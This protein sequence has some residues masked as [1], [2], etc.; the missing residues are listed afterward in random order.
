[1][2]PTEELKEEHDAIKRMLRILERMA[3]RLDAREDV[4]IEDIREAI[5]F[6]QG[7][8]DRCHH[9]KEED[10]LFPAM[11]AAGVPRQTGPIA[12]MLAEHEQGRAH[13]RA[14]IKALDEHVAGVS[15]AAQRLADNAR[16]YTALLR[17]HIDKEDGILYVIA[18]ARLSPRQQEELEKG[19]ARVE[20]EVIG[21]GQHETYHALL[22]RLSAAYLTG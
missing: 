14:M 16:A 11:E 22:D 2:K 20:R 7:F 21:A 8:A 17:Q 13:V 15:D 19:F 4:R 1:M 3:D 9:A 18:D 5:G 6:I 12:V 10:L